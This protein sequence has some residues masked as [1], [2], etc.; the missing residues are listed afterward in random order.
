MCTR[1]VDDTPRA[2]IAK[3]K[4]TYMAAHGAG[5]GSR[6]ADQSQRENQFS[7]SAAG[8]DSQRCLGRRPQARGKRKYP[9][10]DNAP[11]IGAFDELDRGPCSCSACTDPPPPTMRCRFRLPHQHRRAFDGP[12]DRQPGNHSPPRR[13][14]FTSTS[15]Q[16]GKS[17][18]TVDVE[19]PWSR[20]AKDRSKRLLPL[21]SIAT[22]TPVG[23][24]QRVEKSDIRS[25]TWIFENAKPSTS[26][27]INPQT[28]SDADHHT[29]VGQHQNVGRRS[30]YR[31]RYA[32]Q[33]IHPA[34]DS[35]QW[36]MDCPSAWALNSA[37][38]QDRHRIDG[39]ASFLMDYGTNWRPSPNTTSRENRHPQQRLPGHDQAVAG[40]ILR[41]NA[42]ASRP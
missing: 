5:P 28:N 34:A 21:T 33:M 37:A 1:E 22:A 23:S 31:W 25:T 41:K 4:T 36:A 17:A 10:H 18:K 16:A 9:L 32:R 2:H 27:K 42:T 29:G 30:F 3:R 13:K 38:R 26:S 6:G 8:C 14:S 24:D 7:M 40:F 35:A 20:D 11:G 19:S 39:D 12:C 15:I